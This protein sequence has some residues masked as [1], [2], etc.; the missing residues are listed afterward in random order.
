VRRRPADLAITAAVAAAACVLAVTGA[1]AALTAVT[2]I[3]L[4]AAPGYLLGELLLGPAAARLDRVL[5]ATGLALSVPVLGGLVLY[6]AGVPLHKPAWL[7]L[8]AGVTLAADLALFL[9]HRRGRPRSPAGAPRARAEDRAPALRP[10]SGW[11]VHRG[12]AIALAAALLIA[13]GGL[14]LARLGAARQHYP[15]FTQLWLVHRNPQ[16]ATASLGVG[17]HEGGTIRYLVVLLRDGRRVSQWTFSLRNGQDWHQSPRVP[18]EAALR[19][20]LFRL[21]DVSQP[22]RHVTL[23]GRGTPPA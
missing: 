7:A 21:P 12:P 14:A 23:A 9:R 13:G 15:G 11:P 16:A 22:Y 3:A 8:L 2:G 19:V 4:L 5:A 6:S 17:N 1:P 18:A 10:W 20:N